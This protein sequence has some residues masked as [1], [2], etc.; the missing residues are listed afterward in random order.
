MNTYMTLWFSSE[1]KRPSEVTDKLKEIGFVPIK[2]LY[3]YKYD[4]DDGAP[5]DEVLRIGNRV[6]SAL[7]DHKVL[8]NLETMRGDL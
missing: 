8:F 4:W 2:G 1:G 3:D 7:K 5:L 6:Q